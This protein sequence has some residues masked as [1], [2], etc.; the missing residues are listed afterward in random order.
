[1]LICQ[2]FLDCALLGDCIRQVN[3]PDKDGVII[4][5]NN[6]HINFVH[7]MGLVHITSFLNFS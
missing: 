7:N 3:Q 5:Y 1:M 6:A 4:M 2:Q